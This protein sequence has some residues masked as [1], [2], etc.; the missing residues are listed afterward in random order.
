MKIF[1]IR[2]LIPIVSIL[3]L[4]FFLISDFSDSASSNFTITIV[5]APQCFDGQDNDGDTFIDYPNDPDCDSYTDDDE[6]TD[7]PPGGGGGGGGGG[8]SGSSP[9]AGVTI[10]GR[11]YPFS[12][13]KILQDGVLV[14]STLSGGDARF[15]ATIGSLPT[16]NYNFSIVTQDENG[17]PSPPFSFPI[18]I[19]QGS[20]TEISGVFIPP[21]IDVDKAQVRKGDNILIF[22]QTTPDSD[23]T[24]E[25]NSETQVFVET[26]S[27]ND[28]V[29]LSYFNSSP[30][31]YGNHSTRSKAQESVLVASEFGRRVGFVVGDTNVEKEPGAGCNADMNGDFLVNLVD[32][33]ITAFWY[34][35]TLSGDIIQKE[36]DCLNGDGV[37]NLVDFSIMAFYWTG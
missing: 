6:S 3:F 2:K 1:S 26:E 11:A 21:T 5:P 24:I 17:L 30:L 14:V 32:F 35:R 12:T 29:Y 25:V 36:V 28:G 10:S 19:T 20:S 34:N 16:G 7:T 22:G 33:S 23:V 13:I 15:S 37:V 27:D 9:Q 4:T 31:E 18:Y 8:S